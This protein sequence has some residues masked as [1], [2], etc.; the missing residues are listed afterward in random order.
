MQS[1]EG[2]LTGTVGRSSQDKNLKGET[3]R[4][5]QRKLEFADEIELN[6]TVEEE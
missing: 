6:E 2:Q 3:T 4:Q 5:D 1:S